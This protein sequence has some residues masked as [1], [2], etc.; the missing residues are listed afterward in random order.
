LN[1]EVIEPLNRAL[2]PGRDDIA[3]EVIGKPASLSCKKS[4]Q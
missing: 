3:R 2:K 4:F 1:K